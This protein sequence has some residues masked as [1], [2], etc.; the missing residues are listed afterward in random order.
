M[1]AIPSDAQI[2]VW[3]NE[4][5]P[6]PNDYAKWIGML[7]PTLKDARQLQY[8]PKVV[9]SVDGNSFL[10][11]LRQ[12]ALD[13]NNFSI[14]MNIF[15][16]RGNSIALVRCNG[17][18][19]EHRNHLERKRPDYKIPENT[20]HVHVAKQRYLQFTGSKQIG[21]ATPTNAYNSLG[22]ALHYFVR[23]F[24]FVSANTLK[25]FEKYTLPLHWS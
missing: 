23:E 13:A 20:C 9:K 16:K 8:K 7:V 11:Y 10:I 12:N 6:I 5:K 19:D 14:G 25:P 24:G 22:S 2:S 21:Y 18:H 15:R 3:L 4:H 17:W 1:Q